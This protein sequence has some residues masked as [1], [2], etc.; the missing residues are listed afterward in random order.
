MSIATSDKID[1][2]N[3]L[4]KESS[5]KR[6]R[7]IRNEYERPAHCSF[8]PS[9]T[10]RA[11]NLVSPRSRQ[12]TFD[13]LYMQDKVNRKK[14]EH[15]IKRA[16]TALPK[17]CSFKPEIFKLQFN[18]HIINNFKTT[19]TITI[20]LIVYLKPIKPPLQVQWFFES[21]ATSITMNMSLGYRL[22]F[23]TYIS[24][25][26]VA[27]IGTKFNIQGELCTTIRTKFRS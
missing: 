4:F 22:L 11:K 16:Q 5:I 23:S 3:R 27:T 13:K 1:V 15:R 25:F 19:K 17:G 2:F 18:N 7:R 14:R 6:A 12:A 10:K 20:P 24:F 9:I 21:I 26:F 8:R